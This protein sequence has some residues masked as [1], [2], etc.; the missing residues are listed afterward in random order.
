MDENGR[1]KI[2]ITADD[3]YKLYVNGK[4]V[5]LGPAAG[6]YF[7]YYYNE[8]DITD[9]IRAGENTVAVHTYYQGLINRVFVSGDGTPDWTS[10]YGYQFWRNARGGFRGDSA[11]GQLSIVLP[12]RNMVVAVQ[13]LV[14]D[15]QTEVD[16]VFDLAERIFGRQEIIV[17]PCNILMK[18]KNHEKHQVLRGFLHY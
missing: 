9:Y 2:Y 11:C 8:I 12:E 14:A 10:G 3:C 18:Q 17:C 4:F 16:D 1:V 6:F 15:M 7:H 13:A 5:T